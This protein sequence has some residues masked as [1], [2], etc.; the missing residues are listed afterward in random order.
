MQRQPPRRMERNTDPVPCQI[1]PQQRNKADGPDHDFYRTLADKV[2]AESV[3]DLGC[4][5]GIL[6]SMGSQQRCPLGRVLAIDATP[7]K[8]REFQHRGITIRG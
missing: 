5:T 4:G 7:P 1:D 2:S 8:S 6:M 3:L